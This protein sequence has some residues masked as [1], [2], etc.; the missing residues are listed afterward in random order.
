MSTTEKH[1]RYFELNN[2]CIHTKY[3]PNFQPLNVHQL[4]TFQFVL[5]LDICVEL[6]KPHAY[7]CILIPSFNQLGHVKKQK[8]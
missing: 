4:F 1:S 7:F 6:L 5:Y 2:T 3:F 8:K